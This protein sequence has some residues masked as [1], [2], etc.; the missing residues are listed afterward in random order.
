MEASS[1]F[2]SMVLYIVM[3]QIIT[4][5]VRLIKYLLLNRTLIP[6]KGIDC[7]AVSYGS[8]A[9]TT[10]PAAG[11]WFE[12]DFTRF[13]ECCPRGHCSGTFNLYNKIWMANHTH[14]SFPDSNDQ[15]VD[16]WTGLTCG[17]V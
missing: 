16:E 13:V 3:L 14:V 12:N 8:S 17:K 4:C 11:Y 2:M 15:C 9:F 1:I 5:H 6:P 10:L 7:S